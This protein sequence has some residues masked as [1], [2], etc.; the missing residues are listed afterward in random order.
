M[1]R[2]VLTGSELD[3]RSIV[4]LKT[5]FLIEPVLGMLDWK[6]CGMPNLTIVAGLEAQTYNRN[7]GTRQSLVDKA[8]TLHATRTCGGSRR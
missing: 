7:C 5:L 1:L 6:I 8:G 3:T 2:Q 4:V